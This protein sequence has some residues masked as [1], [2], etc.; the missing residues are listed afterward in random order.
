MIA[1]G[2]VS[3]CRQVGGV[4]VSHAQHWVA[5]RNSAGR[6]SAAPSPRPMDDFL[7][8]LEESVER[9][10]VRIRADVVD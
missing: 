7:P 10:R 2:F 1:D 8:K 9:S 5:A 6:P 3:R 4:F